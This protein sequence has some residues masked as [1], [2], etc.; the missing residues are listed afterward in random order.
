MW[1]AVHEGSWAHESDPEVIAPHSTGQ[2]KVSFL[3]SKSSHPLTSAL[4]APRSH[5]SLSHILSPSGP[6]D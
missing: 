6:R 2:E 3:A 5:L 1:P 4:K